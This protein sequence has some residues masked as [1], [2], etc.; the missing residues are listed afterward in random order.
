MPFGYDDAAILA[1]SFMSG[2]FGGGGDG[3]QSRVPFEGIPTGSGGQYSPEDLL[4]WA[5]Q[6]NSRLGMSAN[7]LANRPVRLRSSYV[8]RLPTFTGGGLPFPIGVTGR[9]PALADPSLLETTP[10]TNYDPFGPTSG[11]AN[12]PRPGPGPTDEFTKPNTKPPWN[13]FPGL[14]PP[15]DGSDF[16]GRPPPTDGSDGSGGSFADAQQALSAFNLMGLKT[17]TRR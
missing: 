9:D 7:E 1:A 8:Q 16:P 13:D 5:I 15:T 6:M 17:P 12:G 14:P 4:S 2:L 11:F 3:Q 10:P